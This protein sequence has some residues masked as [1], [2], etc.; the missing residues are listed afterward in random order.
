M[1]KI[2][3][4]FLLAT[5]IVFTQTTAQA[6]IFLYRTGFYVAGSGSVDWNLSNN[7]SLDVN[8]SVP[9]IATGSVTPATGF[10][11]NL[12]LGYYMDQWRIEAEGNYRSRKDTSFSFGGVTVTDFGYVSEFSVMANAYYDIPLCVE[13]WGFYLGLGV[14]C[15][16]SEIEITGAFNAS[17]HQG[18]FAGQ[19]IAGMFYKVH[20]CVALTLAYR[21]FATTS[22]EDISFTNGPTLVTISA[23]SSPI[24][25]SVELGIRISL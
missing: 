21:F 16:F 15:A 3:R 17:D 13:W 19:A 6:I 18:R 4:T 2:T 20:P 5:I 14:G 24:I 22:P 8:T 1:K 25:Q 23:E 11:A 9:T 12:A 10:N 7:V